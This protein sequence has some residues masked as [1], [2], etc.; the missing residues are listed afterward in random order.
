MSNV[1]EQIEALVETF[2]RKIAAQAIDIAEQNGRADQLQRELDAMRAEI[3]ERRRRYFLVADAVARESESAEQ[4]ADIARQ[5]RADLAAANEE[6]A[7]WKEG[8]EELTATGAAYQAQLAAA[9]EETAHWRAVATWCSKHSVMQPCQHCPD[10]RI[11]AKL[12]EETTRRSEMHMRLGRALAALR[13]V[14]HNVTGDQEQ[15]K[16]DEID[17]ILADDESKAAGEAWGEL[18]AVYEAARF[19]F[20]SGTWP[21]AWFDA[22]AKVDARRGAK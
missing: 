15:H 4:L 13:M 20:N 12:G 11:V 5:T 1:A 7:R 3:D 22:L 19:A 10:E 18:E 9:N 14:R 8:V 21:K 6:I 17:A 2:A 16:R